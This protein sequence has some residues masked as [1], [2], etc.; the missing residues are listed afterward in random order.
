MTL[1]GSLSDDLRAETDMQRKEIVRLRK[2][3]ALY[4]EDRIAAQRPV[5][6]TLPPMVMQHHHI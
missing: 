2:L 5:R 3:L 4:E 6:E 1:S